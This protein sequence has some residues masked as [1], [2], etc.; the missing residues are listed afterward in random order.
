MDETIRKHYEKKLLC[1]PKR[2]MN[3]NRKIKE[4]YVQPER[5]N[6]KDTSTKTYFRSYDGIYEPLEPCIC[7]SP[8]SDNK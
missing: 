1:N 6:P 3:E 8:N 7:D 4:I 5:L 2:F